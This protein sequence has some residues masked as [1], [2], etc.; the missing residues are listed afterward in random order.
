MD[1]VWLLAAVA[2]FAL[3]VAALKFLERLRAED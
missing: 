2:F 1:F 3:S